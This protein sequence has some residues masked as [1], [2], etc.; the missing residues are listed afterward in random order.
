[1]LKGGQSF[2]LPLQVH[3]LAVRTVASLSRPFAQSLRV[4]CAF[5]RVTISGVPVIQKGFRESLKPSFVES[6]RY[7]LLMDY[8]AVPF[9]SNLR[10]ARCL[11]PTSGI[12]AEA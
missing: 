6:C 4:A 5:P 12:Y 11:G 8:L 1:M 7:N 10:A 9:L 2:L 3:F